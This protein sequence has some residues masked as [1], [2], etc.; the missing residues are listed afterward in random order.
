[1]IKATERGLAAVKILTAGIAWTM[2]KYDPIIQRLP[3]RNK[4]IRKARGK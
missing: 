3:A 2:L 4:I 1:V